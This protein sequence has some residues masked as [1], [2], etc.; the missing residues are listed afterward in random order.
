MV[1]LLYRRVNKLGHRRAYIKN[2]SSR[3][4]KHSSFMALGAWVKPDYCKPIKKHIIKGLQEISFPETSHVSAH[5]LF[6]CLQNFRNATFTAP[7]V[8][9]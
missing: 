7:R 9:I 1:E 8:T 3:I 5:S 4:L 6:V 2:I